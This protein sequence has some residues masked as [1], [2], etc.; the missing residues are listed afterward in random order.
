MVRKTS[1]FALVATE[2]IH[3][4]EAPFIY[5]TVDRLHRCGVHRDSLYRA[6]ILPPRGWLVRPQVLERCE[7][8]QRSHPGLRTGA[9]RS[10]V[11]RLLHREFQIAAVPP[12]LR[13]MMKL[14]RTGHLDGTP[15]AMTR[16]TTIAAE[17]IEN[18]D[19]RTMRT[20]R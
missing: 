4:A 10:W 7:S 8:H 13:I 19:A 17:S 6:L 3:V 12:P 1:A 9:S 18:P 20:T 14:E 5:L 11:A 15:A 2:S 16:T